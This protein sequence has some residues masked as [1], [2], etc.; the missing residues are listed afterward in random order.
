MSF[1][2]FDNKSQLLEHKPY[3]INNNKYNFQQHQVLNH[4]QN[5]FI[6]Y[7][8]IPQNS[9]ASNIT[10]NGGVLNFKLENLNNCLL[11]DLIFSFKITNSDA[12]NGLN[13]CSGPFIIDK[14]HVKVQ[15]QTK[16]TYNNICHYLKT[17]LNADV[18]TNDKNLLLDSGILNTNLTDGIAMSSS[19]VQLFY[20]EL[21]TILSNLM[22]HTPCINGDLEIQIEIK[23]LISETD[24]TDV[25]FSNPVLYANCLKINS[26]LERSILKQPQLD[27]RVN[28]WMQK[29]YT[30]STGVTSG[31]S[32][33]VLLNSFAY[34]CS[35]MIVYLTKVGDTLANILKTY[36]ISELQVKD[37]NNLSLTNNINYETDFMDYLN[38]KYFFKKSSLFHD[39]NTNFHLISFGSDIQNTINNH[40]FYGSTF[41]KDAKLVFKSSE[42]EANPVYVN[43]IFFV[44]SILRI[45]DGVLNQMY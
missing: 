26:E 41:L 3:Y 15:G 39:T 16:S 45:K 17:V 25:V 5:N 14:C 36:S 18:N 30:I 13:L 44:P 42:T 31:Q 4:S 40:E 29:T 32:Y 10:V 8:F 22:I 6:Q 7:R 12:L 11:K 43:V 9:Y 34:N 37:S 24:E 20:I 35:G 2:N 21:N 23:K 38:H 1:L 33:E 27:Y 19:G 28:D